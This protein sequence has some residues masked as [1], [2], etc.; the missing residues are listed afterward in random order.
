MYRTISMSHGRNSY[1]PRTNRDMNG[2]KCTNIPIDQ[3][4]RLHGSHPKRFKTPLKV[5]RPKL[6]LSPQSVSNTRSYVWELERDLA[7]A[8]AC[9]E[10]AQVAADICKCQV[11]VADH[12]TSIAK[13]DTM[14]AKKEVEVLQ[15]SNTRLA[16]QLNTL[17]FMS[18][19]NQ[20][21]GERGKT[22]TDIKFQDSSLHTTSKFTSLLDAVALECL[23]SGG[24]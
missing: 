11:I 19:L 5:R 21:T 7:S 3:L 13:I 8:I 1:Q 20:S 10:K 17:Y 4:A 2:F 22:D 16:Q 12:L 24:Y 18:Q 6:Q 9:T 14:N 23:P 15:R